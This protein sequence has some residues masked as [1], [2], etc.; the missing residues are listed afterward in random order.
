MKRK[1]AALFLSTMLLSST[2]VPTEIYADEENTQEITVILDGNEISFD[3]P[4]VVENGRTLVPFRAILEAMGADIS[5]DSETKTITCK[6]DD[7]TVLITVGGD[8]INI[9]GEDSP[10]DVPAKIENGR[11][12]VPLR[13]V[14][15]SFKT[16]VLWDAET[17]IITIKTSEATNETSEEANKEAEDFKLTQIGKAYLQNGININTISLSANKLSE[18]D[19]KELKTLMLDF[20]IF[21]VNNSDFSKEIS[22]KNIAVYE[23]FNDFAAKFKAIAEKNDIEI[24]DVNS[25]SDDEIATLFMD[26]DTEADNIISEVLNTSSESIDV[27]LGYLYVKIDESDSEKL[28]EFYS[29]YKKVLDYEIDVLANYDKA[30]ED[31]SLLEEMTKNGKSLL[32][33]IDAFSESLKVI[34]HN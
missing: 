26:V 22:D 14:S 7:T 24:A 23:Q 5:W 30:K 19:T 33:E 25:M 16:E 13:A 17:K 18:E 9:N 1:L 31:S 12:L 2:I 28:D 34:P 29:I 4:P 15:E 11:T 6:K 32:E 8:Y 21:A 20:F 10:V 3:Q 27:L